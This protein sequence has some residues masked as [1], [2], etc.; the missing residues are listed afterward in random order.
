MIPSRRPTK[1][2]GSRKTMTRA[3]FPAQRARTATGHARLPELQHRKT[4]KQLK[5][6][7]G[8]PQFGIFPKRLSLPYPDEEILSGY[9]EDFSSIQ[10]GFSAWVK[11]D[12]EAI[13][14]RHVVNAKCAKPAFREAPGRKHSPSHAGYRFDTDVP[15]RLTVQRRLNIYNWNP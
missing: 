4:H 2:N 10:D 6:T 5:T 11:T 7:G 14:K 13:L 8:V 9:E 3:T 12:P 1:R 15:N